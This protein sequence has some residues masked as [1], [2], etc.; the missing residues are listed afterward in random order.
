MFSA[1]RY[2]LVLH[3]NLDLCRFWLV[4]KLHDGGVTGK[5]MQSTH[6]MLETSLYGVRDSQRH[7][8]G[9]HLIVCQLRPAYHSAALTAL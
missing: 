8:P 1:T 7:E 5:K 2:I 9:L 4:G 6:A 3:R